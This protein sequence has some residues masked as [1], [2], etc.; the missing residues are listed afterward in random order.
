MKRC[1]LNVLLEDDYLYATSPQ[2]SQAALVRYANSVAFKTIQVGFELEFIHFFE[3]DDDYQ[4][5][6]HDSR[7]ARA[8]ATRKMRDH[9][10]GRWDVHEDGSI[11]YYGAR[12]HACV[13][14][15]SPVFPLRDGIIQLKRV[16]DYI[17]QHG[18]TNESTAV[19]VGM[20]FKKRGTVPD[21][22]KMTLLLGE[23]EMLR[24]F[25]R[26]D[27]DFASPVIDLILDNF[28]DA[29]IS[30]LILA[31]TA[32]EARKWL[33][34]ELNEFLLDNAE[35]Y[36]VL[37]FRKWRQRNRYVEVRA[38]GNA[39]YH[40]RFTDVRNNILRA[41]R[42]MDAA[43]DPEAYKKEYAVKLGELVSELWSRNDIVSA[44]EVELA[45]RANEGDDKWC[46]KRGNPDRAKITAEVNRLRNLLR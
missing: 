1:P 33:M 37:N 22:A 25:R 23:T 40:R 17:E 44:I 24:T 45:D 41:A 34:T 9:F 14:L 11:E 21:F 46:N 38:M 27:N 5:D 7:H 39:R 2:L 42:I 18:I 19:H 15:V 13:E 36:R 3:D 29:N 26:I 31:K 8:L 4:Y 10:G 35:K 12:D 20:S 6:M 28:Y 30:G 16:F 43:A 32:A